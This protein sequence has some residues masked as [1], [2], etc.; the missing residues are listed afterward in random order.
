[1]DGKSFLDGCGVGNRPRDGRDHGTAERLAW[2]EQR[3]QGGECCEQSLEAQEGPEPAGLVGW[4]KAFYPKNI[5][6]PVKSF[7]HRS[8]MIRFVFPN[9]HL[10]WSRVRTEAG[11]PFRRL[12]QT[13][14]QEMMF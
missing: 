9:D 10:D 1:M 5:N 8:D 3:K 2:L 14:R 7:N 6:K 13:S 11:R 4:V 12:L